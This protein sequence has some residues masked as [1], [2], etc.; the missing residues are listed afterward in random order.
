MAKVTKRAGLLAALAAATALHATPTY[1]KNKYAKPKPTPEQTQEPDLSF[2]QTTGGLNRLKRL[3]DLAYN[4]AY[5]YQGKEVPWPGELD[6]NESIAWSHLIIAAKLATPLSNP[7]QTPQELTNNIK[8]TL[9]KLHTYG[10][11]VQI[12]NPTL[13]A[14]RLALVK[15]AAHQAANGRKEHVT[16]AQGAMRRYEYDIL[17]RATEKQAPSLQKMLQEQET[18]RE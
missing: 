15:R 6:E 2:Y 1:A 11:G 10:K 17:Q 7:N 16:A 18:I 8:T 14:F 13:E 5:V 9:E 4:H 12:M 3:T